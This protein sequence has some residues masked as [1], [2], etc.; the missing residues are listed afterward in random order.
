MNSK[1][2]VILDVQYKDYNIT[3]D[4][5]EYYV[6]QNKNGKSVDI[7]NKDIMSPTQNCVKF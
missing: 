5:G 6:S 7:I 4:R 1:V 3:P 2:I